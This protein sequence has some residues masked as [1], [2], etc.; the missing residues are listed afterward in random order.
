[1]EQ[2]F[3]III[4]SNRPEMA[5]ETQNCFKEYHSI[6]H[7]GTGYP[8]FS[9]LIND[10]IVKTDTEIVI[11]AND[12]VRANSSHINKMLF[13]LKKGFG[14]VGL[15]RFGFFAITKNLIRTIGFFDERYVGGGYEDS[16]FGKRCLEYDIAIYES[17]EAPYVSTMKSSWNYERA[18]IFYK[19]KWDI[20]PTHWTKILLDEKY[21][22]DLGPIVGEPKWMSF[23]QS[24]LSKSSIIN[25]QQLKFFNNKPVDFS[26]MLCSEIF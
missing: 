11:I 9:K 14:F 6:I 16:D 12:K 19:Q 10:C 8:S 5:K 4:P 2:N 18:Y 13:L 24:M 20:T 1:M 17:P 7:D 23:S 22:Y 21:D 26:K 3:T 25:H 15:Y